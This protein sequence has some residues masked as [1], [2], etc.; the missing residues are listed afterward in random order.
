MMLIGGAL[1]LAGFLLFLT[2]HTAPANRNETEDIKSSETESDGTEILDEI[3][4][5]SE[6]TFMQQNFYYTELSDELKKQITGI[7]YPQAV[8]EPAIAYEELRYVH[9]L[10]YDFMNMVQEGELICN[11][12][13]A[14]DLVEIFAELY[15]A[16]YPIEKV[17]LIDA[18]G[19]N[20]EASMENNNTSC[21][22]YRVVSGTTK[23]SSHAYG[24]A[25]DINPLYNPYISGNG[26]NIQP[27]NAGAYTDRDAAFE[28]K[29]DH[30]DL[31][32][33]LFTEHGFT[34]GGDWT[35]TKDYQHF[36]KINIP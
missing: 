10:H 32:Y 6:E 31:C 33:Q 14:D 22:N 24:L 27:S 16:E 36:E 34:W 9:V 26:Q 7:S 1:L 5:I 25:I 29:I 19:G 20:D 15:L 11:Q 18:Y 30:S 4:E 3:P 28:H 23:L 21:F 2:I 8:D 13:I 35:N 17:K 12:A